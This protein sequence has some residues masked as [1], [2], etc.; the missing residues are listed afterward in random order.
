MKNQ[1]KL[2]LAR[3]RKFKAKRDA[4]IDSVRK[5]RSARETTLP[6]G[7]ADKLVGVRLHVMNRSNGKCECD[8]GCKRKGIKEHWNDKYYLKRIDSIKDY[9]WFCGWCHAAANDKISVTKQPPCCAS[10]PR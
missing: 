1:R 2:T 4:E 8:G 6:G 3:Y 5:K 7:I 10:L 9:R